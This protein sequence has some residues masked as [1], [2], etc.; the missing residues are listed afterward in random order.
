MRILL[1][2]ANG[3]MGRALRSPLAALGDVVAGARDEDPV[4]GMVKADLGVQGEVGWLVEALRPDYV[5][6]AAAYTAVDKAEQEPGLAE[7][8]N[9]HAV[10]EIARAC[11]ASGAALVHI[12]TDYVFD[13]CGK[14]PYEP[15]DPTNPLGVY[16]GSKLRGEQAIRSTGCKHV[17][18]RTAWAYGLEG[19]NFLM[20]M[21]RLGAEREEL[22]VV[23]DQIGSPTPTWWIAEV[24]VSVIRKGVSGGATHH[25]VTDGQVSWHGFAVAIFEEAVAR[26]M[27]VR[28]PKVKAIASDDYPAPAR[29]PPYSVLDT[30]SLRAAYDI[31]PIQ[32]RVALKETFDRGDVC[33]RPEGR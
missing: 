5:V 26:G 15:E 32:W 22:G 7:R 28:G 20:T 25:M 21:L 29:R 14:G 9:H 13:G 11:A 3:Q 19:S 4:A 2:G 30:S 16:G 31:E 17:I 27:L 12:S 6:N 18:L 33:I 8:V 24:I 10:S 1:L 23:T